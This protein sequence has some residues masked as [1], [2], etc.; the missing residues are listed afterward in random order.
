MELRS[1][2][3]AQSRGRQPVVLCAT[4]TLVCDD[5]L[6]VIKLLIA[7]ERR[8]N[9]L[10]TRLRTVPGNYDQLPEQVSWSLENRKAHALVQMGR[11]GSAS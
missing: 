1:C 4:G 8:K 11:S 2:A 3:A 6:T 10:V 5:F 7:V 9:R